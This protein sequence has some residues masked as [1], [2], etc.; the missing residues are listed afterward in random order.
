[1]ATA[2]LGR[3]IQKFRTAPE[4]LHALSDLVNVL[5]SLYL[6]AGIIHRNIAIKNLVIA[7]QR[8]TDGPKTPKGVLVDFDQALDLRNACAEQPQPLVGSDGFMA[9]GILSGQRHTYRH[10]LESLFY[11]FLWLVIG[12]DYEHADASDILEGLPRTSRLWK[13][14]SL[15]LYSVGR[16]KAADMS[17]EGFL[18]IL[19]EFSA[20]FA[21]L[22]GLAIELHALVFPVRDG[23]IF[24]GTE[25]EQVVVEGLYTAMADA[26]RWG[27][28][29]LQN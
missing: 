4:L 23:R 9:I 24:T 2:P 26:F 3:P 6:D 12:N 22:R 1:M 20:D 11:V 7:P 13:W 19:D 15:D 8:S 28:L 17:T 16:A 5:R 29:A 27:A 18:A 21:H 10:D 25:T 14:C